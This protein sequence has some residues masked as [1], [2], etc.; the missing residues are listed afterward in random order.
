MDVLVAGAD[1]QLGRMI[2]EAFAAAGHRVVVSGGRREEL[3]VLAKELD[4]DAVVCDHSDP[5]SVAEAQPRFPHHLDSIVMV[6]A[7]TWW[8]GADARVFTLTDTAAA[9]RSSFDRTVVAAV[10][11]VAGV[12]DNLRSGG[13]IVAVLP[14]APGEAGPGQAVKAAV[15]TWTAAHADHFGT[16]GI[17]INTVACG[18]SAQPGYDGLAS[19]VPSTDA[20]LA[21]LALFLTTPAARHITGQTLH[22]G[23]GTAASFG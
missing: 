7:E 2:A 20:A 11:T 12:G 9:W 8:T 14:D 5:A 13:S 16:R 18:R 15:S 23:G 3:E 19:T 22:V 6:P 17:T 1:T 21:R 4:V 10:I